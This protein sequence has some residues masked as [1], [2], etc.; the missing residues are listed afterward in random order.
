AMVGLVFLIACANVANILLAQSATRRKEISVRLS[1][2]AT[3][4][5]LIRQVLTESI[6][7]A[8]L[9]GVVSLGLAVPA[10]WA[11]GR[12][13]LPT[14][15]PFQLDLSLDRRVLIFTFV[16]SLLAGLLF[17]LLPALRLTKMDLVA[18]LNAEGGRGGSGAGKGRL[19]NLLVIAQV[20]VSM[21]VL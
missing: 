15:I 19:R 18:T 12:V 1:L 6:M 7:L 8:L 17:G 21:V 20:A 13:K 4:W 2:G 14:D 11:L 16:I 9:S 3:R 10:R 5:R